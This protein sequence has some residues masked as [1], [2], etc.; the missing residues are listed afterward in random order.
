MMIGGDKCDHCSKTSVDL[1]AMNFN[2]CRSCQRAYYCSPECQRA[3]WKAGHKQACCKPDE[4]YVGDLMHLR[5]LQKRT[6]INERLVEMVEAVGGDRWL[7]RFYC[8]RDGE[9]P[10]GNNLGGQKQDRPYPPFQV[11][12]IVKYL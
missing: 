6:K 12:V 11:A 7:V 10:G 8:V 2:A 1:G 3:A 9:H 5:S 4:R